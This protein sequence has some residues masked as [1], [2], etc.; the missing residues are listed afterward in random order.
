MIADSG[1]LGTGTSCGRK[2]NRLKCSHGGEN[3]SLGGRPRELILK[4]PY[5]CE[6]I[7]VS[8]K[9]REPRRDRRGSAPHCSGERIQ[10]PRGGSVPSDLA[11]SGLF[12]P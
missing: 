12:P 3:D 2:H 7:K 10:H 6:I 1:V 11:A 9:T 4:I 5:Y 8:R